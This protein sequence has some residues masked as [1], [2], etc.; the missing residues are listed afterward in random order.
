MIHGAR[1]YSDEY[2]VQNK[3][4]TK[5]AADQPTEYRKNNPVPRKMSH[6][7]PENHTIINNVVG[8]LCMIESK[9]LSA[10]NHEAPAFL[11]SDYGENNLYQ[12]EI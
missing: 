4:G 1:H 12:V 11:E 5:Y 6:K 9:K 8:E 3:F 7:K 10:V 2:K